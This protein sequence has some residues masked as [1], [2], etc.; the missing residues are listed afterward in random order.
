MSLLSL[1]D[2]RWVKY[3]SG[4]NR[5]STNI[6]EWIEVLLSDKF[7]DTHWEYLWDELHHQND[8]GEAAYAV[9]PYLAK[10]AKETKS[11][12][13]NI[14]A[15][16]VVVELARLDIENPV[17]PKEIEKNYFNAFNILAKEAIEKEHWENESAG[18]MSACIAL[19]KGQRLLARTYLELAAH[20]SAANYLESEIGWVANKNDL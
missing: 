17:I 8:V 7:D 5:T 15:F 20:E 11:S 4:Y 10:Y 14:W 18:C 3:R 13:W 9:I 12:N 2:P 19:A 6:V 1:S 16:P